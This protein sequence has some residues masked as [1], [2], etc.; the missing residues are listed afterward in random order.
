MGIHPNPTRGMA[1]RPVALS[2]AFHGLV[3]HGLW[4]IQVIPLLLRKYTLQEAMES[5]AFPGKIM[6]KLKI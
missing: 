3:A 4:N 2:H 5:F 1:T 6:M